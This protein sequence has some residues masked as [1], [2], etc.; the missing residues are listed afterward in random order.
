MQY[1]QH[2]SIWRSHHSFDIIVLFEFMLR[3]NH[4]LIQNNI[5]YIYNYLSLH[6]F[7]S[8]QLVKPDPILAHILRITGLQHRIT[9]SAWSM[10]R[11]WHYL[12]HWFGKILSIFL[13]VF[14]F[15]WYFMHQLSPHTKSYYNNQCG[16]F[17][18]ASVGRLQVKIPLSVHKREPS[19]VTGNYANI[20]RL[21][22]VIWSQTINT[23]YKL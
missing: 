22:E 18:L 9:L 8:C 2:G 7:M 3:M 15:V 5:T 6:C 17:W 11:C 13:V 23:T 20:R 10:Y 19:V 16:V 12:Y 1:S 14:D 4:L 21:R